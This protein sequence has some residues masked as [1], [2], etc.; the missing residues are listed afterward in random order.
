MSLK[1]SFK[2]GIVEES[3]DIRLLAIEKEHVKT[4]EQWATIKNSVPSALGR[5]ELVLPTQKLL[6]MIL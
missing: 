3:K 4:V 5:Q 1:V 6:Q 2:N